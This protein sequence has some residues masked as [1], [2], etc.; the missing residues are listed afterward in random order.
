MK[1]RGDI[2]EAQ[3][4]LVDAEAQRDRVRRDRP[5]IE[6]EVRPLRVFFADD[7]LAAR[8]RRALTG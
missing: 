1:R 2:D 3:Q 4:A 7:N 6:R 5:H 8:F